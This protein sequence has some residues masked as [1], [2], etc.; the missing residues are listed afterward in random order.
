MVINNPILF[1]TAFGA[2]GTTAGA[3]A[4]AIA[5]I[6]A[7]WQVKHSEKKKLRLVFSDDMKMVTEGSS[8][9]EETVIRLRV[10][11]V[12]N[13]DVVVE[14]W[15]YRSHE[16]GGYMVLG[17]NQ[18]RLMKNL[19]PK[20]P[21]ELKKEDSLNLMIERANFIKQIKNGVDSGDFKKNRKIRFFVADSTGKEYY[22]KSKKTVGEIIKS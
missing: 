15:G 19:N 3:I 14:T 5:V 7:L 21:C 20:L 1:W 8:E 22:V 18:S 10:V 17:F 16:K 9:I 13:R 4:T 6:V 11:N 12:G 2:I